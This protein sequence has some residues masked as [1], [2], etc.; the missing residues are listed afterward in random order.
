MATPGKRAEQSDVFKS[1]MTQPLHGQT[2]K[3]GDI[4]EVCA[5]PPEANS[6]ESTEV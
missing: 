6:R 2:L 5:A 4:P 3:Q 1:F